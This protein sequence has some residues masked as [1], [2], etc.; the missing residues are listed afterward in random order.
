MSG[1]SSKCIGDGS[2]TLAKKAKDA[3][4]KVQLGLINAD[5]RF[6][7]REKEDAYIHQGILLTDEIYRGSIHEE[8]KGHLFHYQV[9]RWIKSVGTFI[10]TYQKGMVLPDG[11]Y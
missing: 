7:K 11:Q 1:K 6:V 2:K 10:C 9:S 5:L 8:A 3:S 4:S